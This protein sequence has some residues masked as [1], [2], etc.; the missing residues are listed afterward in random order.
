MN[1]DI[2]INFLKNLRL[3]SAFLKTSHDLHETF[4]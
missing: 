1:S 2:L 4:G 3:E